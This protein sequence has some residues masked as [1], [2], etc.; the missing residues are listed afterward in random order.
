[1]RKKIQ[2]LSL[3]GRLEIEQIICQKKVGQEFTDVKTDLKQLAILGII[4][5]YRIDKN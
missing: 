2:T 3:F 1:M 5:A 4:N